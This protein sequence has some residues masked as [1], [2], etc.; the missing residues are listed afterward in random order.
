MVIKV[1]G[2]FYAYSPFWK[3][4]PDLAVWSSSEHF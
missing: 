3:L 2:H 4:A 1:V